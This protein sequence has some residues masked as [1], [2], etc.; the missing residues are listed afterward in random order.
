MIGLVALLAL[1]AFGVYEYEKSSKTAPAKQGSTSPWTVVRTGETGDLTKGQ[2]ATVHIAN[3]TSGQV[4]SLGVQVTGIPSDT[5][6]KKYTLLVTSFDAA[7]P[8]AAFNIGT[9]FEVT[10]DYILDSTKGPTR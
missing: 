8:P 9:M 6:S 1:G 2:D 10:R 5:P 3:T 7:A 4:V